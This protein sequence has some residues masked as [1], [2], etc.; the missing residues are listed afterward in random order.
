M[1]KI[2][3]ALAYISSDSCTQFC[4]SGNYGDGFIVGT[5]PFCSAKCSSDCSSTHCSLA[6]SRWSDYGSG[7]LS[8]SK[9]CCCGKLTKLKL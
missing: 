8:G 6:H 4:Q 7:C 2:E 5:A 3:A 9:I 1:A